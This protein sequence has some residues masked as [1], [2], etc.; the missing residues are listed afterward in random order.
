MVPA[1]LPSGE[2][3][4]STGDAINNSEQVAG[5]LTTESQ[6]RRAYVSEDGQLSIL[7]P[8]NGAESSTANDI[9]DAGLVV[10]HSAVS[11]EARA[12]LWDEG[13][14]IDLTQQIDP[15]DPL[16]DTVRLWNALLINDR[17]QI[18]ANARERFNPVSAMTSL[19]ERE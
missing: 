13:V 7:P 9:N 4:D 6:G 2:P 1:T 11:G 10:G 15:A 17:G 5:S 16:H 3:I 14:A 12:T 19:I 8:L 18:V